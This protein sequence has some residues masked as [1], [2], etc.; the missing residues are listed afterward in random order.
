MN[1]IDSINFNIYEKNMI[2]IINYIIIKYNLDIKG[3]FDQKYSRMLS[4]V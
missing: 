2:I 4:H 1:R 3:Q